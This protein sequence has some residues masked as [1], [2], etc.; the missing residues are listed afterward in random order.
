MSVLEEKLQLAQS[1]RILW[2]DLEEKYAQ[3]EKTL[4]VLMYDEDPALID[5]VFSSLP[6]FLAKKDYDAAVIL[7]MRKG[8]SRKTQEGKQGVF[9]EVLSEE[10]GE[11]LLSLYEMYQFTSSLLIVSLKRPFGSKLQQLQE[12][13]QI[14]L[15]EL[16]DA[17]LFPI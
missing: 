11:S 1:G 8:I 7:E 16:V 14:P 3:F 12:N 15:R 6:D 17:C 13:L 9:F 5:A 4:Y 2:Q 10:Q